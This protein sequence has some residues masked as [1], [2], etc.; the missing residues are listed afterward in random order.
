MTLAR[1]PRDRVLKTSDQP[2]PTRSGGPE[3]GR[4]SGSK[5]RSADEAPSV[6]DARGAFYEI[7]S[8]DET[9]GVRLHGSASGL[10]FEDA[11][12]QLSCDS[13]DFWRYYARGAYRGQRLHS[14]AAA[15]RE[16]Q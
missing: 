7:W 11:C 13:L 12:K 9:G 3:G 4:S 15:A 6:N 14:S 16:D 8:R 2:E 5:P 1:G 10:T